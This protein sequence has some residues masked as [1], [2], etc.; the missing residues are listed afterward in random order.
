MGFSTVNYTELIIWCSAMT[1]TM[2]RLRS[3]AIDLHVARKS[4]GGILLRYMVR[5]QMI[6]KH[7]LDVMTMDPVLARWSHRRI[8]YSFYPQ[9]RSVQESKSVLDEVSNHTH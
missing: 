8:A 4:S 3:H 5:K 2:S 9:Q 7:L 6:R 1:S